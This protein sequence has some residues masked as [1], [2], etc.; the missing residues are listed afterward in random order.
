MYPFNVRV[1]GLLLQMGCVLISDEKI[2]GHEMTKFPGGGLEYGEG[3]LE[4]LKREFREELQQDITILR[5]FYTTDFF[6]P[7]A[8]NKS[9]VISIYYL[10]DTDHLPDYPQSLVPCSFNEISHQPQLAFRWLPLSEISEKHFTFAGDK[11]VAEL[12]KNAL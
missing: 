7:S 4:G 6:I 9:Q 12:L 2:N 10:V 5:H 3:T 1:Y 8:F 11:K